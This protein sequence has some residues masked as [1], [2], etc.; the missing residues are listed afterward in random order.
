MAKKIRKLLLMSISAI[1]TIDLYN[2]KIPYE[3]IQFI[4]KLLDDSESFP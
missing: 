1:P 2:I 4:K 3:Y